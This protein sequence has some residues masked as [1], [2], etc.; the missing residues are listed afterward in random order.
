MLDGSANRL[1]DAK[2]D[3]AVARIECAGTSELVER[4]AGER[5]CQVKEE[6]RRTRIE[7]ERFRAG[8]TRL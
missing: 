4:R 7:T 5:I 8:W 6:L 2:A 3:A 1:V